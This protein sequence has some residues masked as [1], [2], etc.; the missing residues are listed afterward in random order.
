MT[1]IMGTGIRALPLHITPPRRRLQS[2]EMWSRMAVDTETTTETIGITMCFGRESEI[3]NVDT[4][5]LLGTRR[6]IIGVGC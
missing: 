5:T 1:A 4:V 2:L 3:E 6:S